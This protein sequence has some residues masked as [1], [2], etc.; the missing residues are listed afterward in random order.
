MVTTSHGKTGP[1]ADPAA[2]LRDLGKPVG[3]DHALLEPEPLLGAWEPDGA[4]WYAHACCGA[5][6]DGATIFRGLLAPGSPVDAL[7]EGIAGLGPHVAPLPLALLGARSR[8][9]RSSATSSRRSTGPSRTTR[10]ASR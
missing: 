4:I 7:L 3:N 8:C 10:R 1:L 9:A 5:G 2:M 6:C